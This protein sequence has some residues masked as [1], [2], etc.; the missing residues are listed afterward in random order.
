MGGKPLPY[1]AE[2]EY[3]RSSGTQW[4]D[5]QLK[6]ATYTYIYDGVI[7]DN[8]NEVVF[9]ADSSKA[10]GLWG[11]QLHVGCCYGK[12]YYSTT[13]SPITG[14]PDQRNHVILTSSSINVN[15]VVTNYGGNY[16]IDTTNSICLF[17]DK[18]G[19]YKFSGKIYSFQ[20]VDAGVILLDF[21]PVRVGQVGYMYDKV[22]G[23][24]F[25]NAGTGE[26]VLGPD[27]NSVNVI[28]PNQQRQMYE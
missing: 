9:G 12:K 27:V 15:G 20:I 16:F 6:A 17:S 7:R 28:T 14:L 21:I 4:I 13:N 22:S 2:V 10:L 1:D 3:L 23:K 5:T 19:S 25:G 11:G 8:P 18:E 24:L 26:F